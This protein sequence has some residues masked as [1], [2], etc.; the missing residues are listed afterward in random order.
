MNKIKS[1]FIYGGLLA[2]TLAIQAN[3]ATYNQSLNSAGESTAWNTALW[4]SPA[5]AAVSGNI[6]VTAAGLMSP[7][8][9]TKMGLSV[10]GRV[11]AYGGA[12]AGDSLRIVAGT[13]LLLK[14]ATAPHSANLILDNGS[15][16]RLS[17]N[18]A[19]AHQLNGS[20]LVAGESYIGVVHSI[21]TTL[22][23]NSTI[24][25]GGTLK[26][27]AGDGSNNKLV[28]SGDLSRFFGTIEMGSSFSPIAVDFTAAAMD[29][30]GAHLSMGN[31]STADSLRLSASLT[32]NSFTFGGTGLAPGTYSAGDLNAR[33]GNGSQF[34]DNG[35]TLTVLQV[36]VLPKIFIIG[37]STVKN[38]SGRVGWGQTI[39]HY[40]KHGTTIV[41]NA[42][43]G[44]STK[45]FI[46]ENRWAATI[47]EVKVDDY[48][49]IQFGHNDSHDPVYPESTDA[50]DDYQTNLLT[51]IN[52][53]RAKGGI[54]VLVTPMHRR[55]FVNGVLQSYA[56]DGG[57]YAM[58]L[59]PYAAA[60]KLVAAA[61]NVPCVDLFTM[62]GDYMQLLG[63]IKCQSL[64]YPGDNTH[65]N[66]MG[67]S[68]MA[69]MMAKGLE[70]VLPPPA[71]PSNPKL[72]NSC[73]RT[74]V[75]HMHWSDFCTGS[76]PRPILTV[77]EEER[78]FRIDWFLQ[79][80]GS[81]I[82]R[83]TDLNEWADYATGT[84]GSQLFVPDAPQGFFR[85]S[86]P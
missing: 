76:F 64:L 6:Y 23:I 51:F 14:D 56:L 41:N 79:R 7:A 63:D 68:A 81:T 11:R 50:N 54:P 8:S 19:G 20:V 73:L 60:M 65:F 72:L 18:N 47:A 21:A 78:N 35:G 66:E 75:I 61:N 46:S 42:N 53:S 74:S 43:P 15:V 52:E 45:T 40:L 62:S 49:L 84:T 55:N 12:F 77:E 86:T 24:S 16:L 28:F 83:C 2:C 26:L 70:E 82:Q 4:G 44:E 9:N 36:R 1:A 17:P 29:L 5:A 31:G 58:D 80:A 22:T 67:A 33:F 59:A 3:A 57:G 38:S 27:R 34:L 85:V 71:N 48:V 69:A 32:F 39:Y 30:A 13:E 25:G 37:D 10:T